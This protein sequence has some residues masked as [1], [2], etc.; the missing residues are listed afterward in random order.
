MLAKIIYVVKVNM[1]NFNYKR[2]SFVRL[3]KLNVYL[4]RPF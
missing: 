1:V 2:M 4:C 3:V